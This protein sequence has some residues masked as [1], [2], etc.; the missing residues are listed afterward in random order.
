MAGINKVILVGNVGRD[1]EVRTF[2]D[3]T[4]VTN[5]T[6]ATSESWTDKQTGEKKE[7]TE[8]HR[9]VAFRRL[10]EICSQYL[11]KGKQ[12]Y[13]EGK[14]QTR[15]WEEKDGTRRFTTEIVAQ[16]MQ[17]LGGRDEGGANKYPQKQQPKRQADIVD[18]DDEDIPF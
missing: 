2:Q 10:A 5:F 12:V 8:W 17:M 13:I 15:E 14:L 18:D 1:P 6:I 16:T 11:T 4:A 9:V 7:R 3:G